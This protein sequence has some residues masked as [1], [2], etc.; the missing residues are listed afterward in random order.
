MELCIVPFNKI[1]TWKT[2]KKAMRESFEQ[3]QLQRNYE[4][5]DQKIKYYNKMY[6]I[7]LNNLNIIKFDKIRLVALVGSAGHFIEEI[8]ENI[9]QI[10]VVDAIDTIQLLECA[11]YELTNKIDSAPW[12]L[13]RLNMQ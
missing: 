11:I 7:I 5:M 1:Y 9:E 4:I 2:Q 6:E 8:C 3:L 12:S 13:I 10:G